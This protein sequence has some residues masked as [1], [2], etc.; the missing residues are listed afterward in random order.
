MAKAAGKA[1]REFLPRGYRNDG[2]PFGRSEMGVPNGVLTDMGC[3]DCRGVLAVRE[4]GGKGHLSFSCRVGHAYSGESLIEVKE[5]Q[6]EDSLWAAVEVFEEV[7]LLHSELAARARRNGARQTA[8]AYERRTKQAKVQ[9]KN[10]RALIA[11]D[12]PASAGRNKG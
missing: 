3:P 2:V 8:T 1:P 9:T 4:E 12:R 7:A 11:E 10:L 6:L 5:Q